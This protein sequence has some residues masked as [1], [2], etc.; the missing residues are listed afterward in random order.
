MEPEKELRRQGEHPLQDF[1]DTMSSVVAWAGASILAL[2]GAIA[3]VIIG[4]LTILATVPLAGCVIF[5]WLAYATRRGSTKLYS[6]HLETH[7]GHYPWRTRRYPLAQIAGVAIY[8]YR[9]FH[10]SG[11]K[12]DRCC[13]IYWEDANKAVGIDEITMYSP[14]ASRSKDDVVRAKKV[15]R[16][17]FVG[18]VAV[19][20]ERQC[21]VMQGPFGPITKGIHL[22]ED[23]EDKFMGH[24][25]LAK[26]TSPDSLDFIDRA[27]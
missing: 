17:S 16:E 20:I 1:H 26:W 8:A 5:A 9:V 13:L 6:D 11:V 27:Q 21:Q 2:G 18:R 14:I 3:I 19:A 23:A 25:P 12:D 15:L 10:T 7:P 24:S 4:K 22:T